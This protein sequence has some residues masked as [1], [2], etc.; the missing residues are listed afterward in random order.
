MAFEA[1]QKV[2]QTEESS[3]SQKAE[4]AAQAKKIVADAQRAGKQ[5]VASARAEAEEKAK[6]MLAQAEELAA[7]QSRQVLEGNAV[8][9]EALKQEA[10]G[11]LDRAADLIVGRVGKN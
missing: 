5:L 1:I 4:A 9:C 2:T 3:R 10:R 11:R 8:A 6:A 7:Q